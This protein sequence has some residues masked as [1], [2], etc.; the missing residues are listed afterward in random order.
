[1]YKCLL[2]FIFL[3]IFCKAQSVENLD[4]KNGF[5]GFHLGDTV[6]NYTA[7]IDPI[8]NKPGFYEAKRKALKFKGFVD[9]ATLFFKDGILSTIELSIGN[10]SD[11]EFM[12]DAIKK[13]Y[14]NGILIKKNDEQASSLK[15]SE[16]WQGKRV[17]LITTQTVYTA[18]YNGKEI[19]IPSGET[20]TIKTTSNIKIEGSLSPD[21]IL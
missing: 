14:G 9:K 3:P 7:L 20:I 5:L 11:I 10:K 6:S 16:V 12:D 19:S 8:K 17:A 2:L 4:I 18:T 13:C 21:F 15:T 1:M